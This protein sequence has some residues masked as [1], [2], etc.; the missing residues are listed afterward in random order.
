MRRPGL[1][2][3]QRIDHG[4]QRLRI[5]IVAIVDDR[6]VTQ[7][8]NLPALVGRRE[9]R[10]R[11]DRFGRFQPASQTHGYRGQG[12]QNIVFSDQRQGARAHDR[13]R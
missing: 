9:S 4:M 13:R 2:R 7:L 8:E 3:S 12:I 5:G 6:D 10:Q 11:G 1:H